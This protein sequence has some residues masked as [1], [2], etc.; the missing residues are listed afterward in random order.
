MAP[1][2]RQQESESRLEL[3]HAFGFARGVPHTIDGLGLRCRGH[4][5]WAAER[6]YGRAFMEEKRAAA[7]SAPGP[8]GGSGASCRRSNRVRRLDEFGYGQ[9]VRAIRAPLVTSSWGILIRLDLWSRL[10][11]GPAHSADRSKART[12][13]PSIVLWHTSSVLEILAP[14]ARTSG[15]SGRF[16]SAGLAS[17]VFRE[18]NG[19]ADELEPHW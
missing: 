18:A 6:M 3:E 11:W 12:R 10:S 4:N 1:T 7:A 5:Q 19:L 2:W 8:R 16:E 14:P 13:V 9:P 17:P 15:V